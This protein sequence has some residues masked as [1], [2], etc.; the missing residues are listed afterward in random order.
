MAAFKLFSAILSTHTITATGSNASYPLTNLKT[1]LARDQWRGAN[2]TAPQYL[3][4]DI[5]AVNGVAG[6]DFMVIENSNFATLEGGSGTVT[7][8]QDD[9]SGF[10]SPTDVVTDVFGGETA[11]TL[12]EFAS[13]QARYWRL[14]F[15]GTLAAAPAL[16]QIFLG[17]TLDFDDMGNGGN[18]YDFGAIRDAAQFETSRGPSLDGTLRASQVTL[19]RRVWELPFS[20]LS[21]AFAA[22]FN[23]WH[24]K[25]RGGLIPFYM[26]DMD[27]ATMRYVHLSEDYHPITKRH[28]N[29]NDID[30]IKL[31]AQQADVS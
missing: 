30:V 9:N 31:I 10:T 6:I 27:G 12:Y 5:G 7:L 1:Y 17:K 21:D 18:G 15:D 4:L 24:D 2:T 13:V 23:A 19:G 26:L 29:Q 16:G 28:Y 11:A 22:T 25:V 14:E 3:N 8:Q 20:L